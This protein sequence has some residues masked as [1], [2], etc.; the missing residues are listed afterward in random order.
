M[1][2]LRKRLNK[3]ESNLSQKMAVVR[4]PKITVIFRKGR[5]TDGGWVDNNP[6]SLHEG[7]PARERSLLLVEIAA[8]RGCQADQ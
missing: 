3:L 1:K 2:E 7:C 8:E 6:L 4:A 5:A